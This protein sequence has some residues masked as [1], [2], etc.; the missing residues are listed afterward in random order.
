[1]QVLLHHGALQA[2]AQERP[3][4]LRPAAVHVTKSKWALA[5]IHGRKLDPHTGMQRKGAQLLALNPPSPNYCRS[6]AGLHLLASR[7]RTFRSLGAAR[8]R[9]G[10]KYHIQPL[11]R[12]THLKA[13]ANAD[14]AALRIKYI[15]GVPKQTDLSFYNFPIPCRGFLL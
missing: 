11:Q 5:V 4:S 2:Y 13:R 10:M 8:R 1:M 6:W 7:T 9:Y 15:L 14:P 3:L 12:Q